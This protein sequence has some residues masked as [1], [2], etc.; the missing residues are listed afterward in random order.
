LA[1]ARIDPVIPWAQ[2]AGGVDSHVCSQGR[3]RVYLLPSRLGI[4]VVL[5]MI[6]GG[7]FGSS[8]RQGRPL[9]PEQKI[10]NERQ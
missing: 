3:L 10:Y 2:S 7:F 8:L 4:T 9:H 1:A 5:F 6:S